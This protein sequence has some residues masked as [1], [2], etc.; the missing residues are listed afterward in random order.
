MAFQFSLH[1]KLRSCALHLALRKANSSELS[2]ASE[3]VRFTCAP[4]ERPWYVAITKH[5]IFRPSKEVSLWICLEVEVHIEKP[6]LRFGLT[7]FLFFLDSLIKACR[8]VEPSGKQR[9]KLEASQNLPKH[10]TLKASNT[11]AIATFLV[12]NSLA[13][14]RLN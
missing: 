6:Q 4:Q 5:P 7:S 3:A 2:C 14:P 13:K 11:S 1:P 12:L 9:Q 10:Q 8:Q